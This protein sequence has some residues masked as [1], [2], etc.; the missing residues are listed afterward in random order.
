MLRRKRKTAED[1]ASQSDDRRGFFR[2]PSAVQTVCQPLAGD[3]YLPARV[4]DVSPTGANL[5]VTHFL[6]EGTMVR[7]TVPGTPGGPHTTILAC[8]M[9]ARELSSSSWAIGCM[10]TFELSPEEM[11]LFSGQKSENGI[12]SRRPWVRSASKGTISYRLLLADGVLH[13]AE[14]S[15]LSTAG[16]GLIVDEKLDAGSAL[17]VDLHCGNDKPNRPMLACVV[18]ATDRPD[19]KWAAGCQFL[20]ELTNPELRELGWQSGA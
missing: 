19:E 7:V 17:L 8:V 16:V 3:L 6:T 12:D 20:R 18:Y 9:H 15:D 4:R 2:Q 11:R 14:V 1:S 5:I 13:K 10:F